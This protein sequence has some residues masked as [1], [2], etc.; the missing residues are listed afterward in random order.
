M[1]GEEAIGA[2]ATG[3]GMHAVVAKEQPERT[4]TDK[5]RWLPGGMTGAAR[6]AAYSGPSR[7]TAFRFWTAPGAPHSQTLSAHP[8]DRE[9]R[10]TT[11]SV[12][13]PTPGG[14]QVLDLNT[15][16]WRYEPRQT[17]TTTGIGSTPWR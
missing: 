14:K 7:R 11:S 4:A 10:V 17:A 13:P 2:A 6:A 3:H 9:T 12:E 8:L 15:R 1:G 16:P 5:A